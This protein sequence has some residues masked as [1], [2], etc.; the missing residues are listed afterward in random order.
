ML[1]E[2]FFETAAEGI[3]E[4]YSDLQV[5][6]L[7]NLVSRL[8][9]TNYTIA[10]TDLWQVEKLGQ[11]GMLRSDIYMEMSRFSGRSDEE[12]L[13]MFRNTAIQTLTGVVDDPLAWLASSPATKALVGDALVATAGTL[14][15][16]TRS[17]ANSTL[18]AYFNATDKAWLD[19]RSGAFDYTTAIT[20]AVGDILDAG[21]P[22][23]AYPTG[24]VDQ[25]DVA[26]RRAALTGA[27]QSSM[28]MTIDASRY[29]GL[30]YVDVSAHA[31]ARPSHAEWQ[32]KRYCLTDGDP[33]FPEL[34][35][36]TGY[37]T[38][39]GLGGWNCRH[40]F[41]PATRD[42]GQPQ[43]AEEVEALNDATV[44]YR[45]KTYSVYDASQEQRRM[46]RGIR[47]TKR[48]VAAYGAMDTTSPELA[49]AREKLK[50]QTLEYRDFSKGAR[51]P[52]G[53]SMG[54]QNE[55]LQV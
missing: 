48:E 13:G 29:L 37:G 42:A 34:S 55:R 36:V 3:V 17:T 8:C 19:I 43:T 38:G 15:N 23:V 30:E 20:R 31:G 50:A 10:D 5:R 6:L 2:R 7:E 51:T 47:A 18:G 46:E 44:E 11:A 49:K 16:I 53:E 27:N 22:L 40:T 54:T 25:V 52:S 26:V 35:A 33:D 32:G 24:H 12:L 39:A 4:L 14:K 41:S 1:D 28:R 21:T 45:G 9:D